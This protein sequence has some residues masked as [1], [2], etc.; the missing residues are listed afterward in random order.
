MLSDGNSFSFV[1]TFYFPTV[2]FLWILALCHLVKNP[3]QAHKEQAAATGKQLLLVVKSS[4]CSDHASLSLASQLRH[5]C[6]GEVAGR[7]GITLM[8]AHLPT[9]LSDT[10][11]LIHL[12]Q[13]LRL[14]SL[15]RTGG[16]V[17]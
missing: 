10:V 4:E 9:V 6:R 12:G 13:L 11:V 8:A 14:S 15:G 2:F 3:Y 17:L 1:D 16:A 5:C 7:I